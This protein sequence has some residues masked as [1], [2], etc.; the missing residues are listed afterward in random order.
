MSDSD[1]DNNGDYALL[2]AERHPLLSPQNHHQQEPETV[3]T[4]YRY[5]TTRKPGIMPKVRLPS[6]KSKS[7]LPLA[8]N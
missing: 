4:T 5:V 8:K 2:R 1:E 3:S 7:I 6:Q